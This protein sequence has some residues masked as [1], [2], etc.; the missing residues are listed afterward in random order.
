[1]DWPGR[2]EH[3]V[4]LDGG[5]ALHRSC[6]ARHLTRRPYGER[7]AARLGVR[8]AVAPVCAR[9]RRGAAGSNSARHV[10]LARAC[11]GHRT[12]NGRRLAPTYTRLQQQLPTAS[13]PGRRDHLH[14]RRRTQ[15][16]RRERRAASAWS[17]C[18]GSQFSLCGQPMRAPTAPDAHPPARAAVWAR[19]GR[20]PT[21]PTAWV[22]KSDC[23]GALVPAHMF[24]E[25]AFAHLGG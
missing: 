11:R 23:S 9:V 18:P 7:L 14:R 4:L 12:H 2:R 5:L 15:Q 13:W 3:R 21:D 8:R 24:A 6:G 19:E 10:L 16:R 1:M 25:A 20:A 17:K 22:P